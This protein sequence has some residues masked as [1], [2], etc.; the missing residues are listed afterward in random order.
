MHK[1]RE[2]CRLA[3]VPCSTVHLRNEQADFKSEQSASGIRQQCRE[4]LEIKEL[5]KKYIERESVKRF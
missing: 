2:T 5:L 1:K 3:S 4:N